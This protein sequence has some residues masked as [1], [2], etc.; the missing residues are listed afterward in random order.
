MDDPAALD[1]LNRR[2]GEAILEDGRVYVGTTTYLGKVCF[3][4]AIVNWRTR[5][6]DVDLLVDVIRDLGSKI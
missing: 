6:E 5:E 4:P 3:R 2:V 1:D